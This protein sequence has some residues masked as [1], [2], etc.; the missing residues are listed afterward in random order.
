MTA[1]RT[2]DSTLHGLS[3]RSLI[4]PTP[5]GSLQIP[6]DSTISSPRELTSHALESSY[7]QSRRYSHSVAAPTTTYSAN[8]AA[9][10]WED[11]LIPFEDAERSRFSGGVHR[12]RSSSP[13]VGP[14]ADRSQIK[15]EPD[16]ANCQF[17]LETYTDESIESPIL[18]PSPLEV[19][20]SGTTSKR[21]RS[22]RGSSDSQ[23][24]RPNS[25]PL[26]AVNASPEMY[27]MMGVIRLDPFACVNGVPQNKNVPSLWNGEPRPLD[28]EPILLEWQVDLLEPLVPQ[29]PESEFAQLPEIE[30]EDGFDAVKLGV[31]GPMRERLRS[32]LS[33][34]WREGG[35]SGARMS[36]SSRGSA[37]PILR[38]L[39]DPK[40]EG[41]SRSPPYH[42]PR[43][44]AHGYI[45]HRDSEDNSA[46]FPLSN[47]SSVNGYTGLSTIAKTR[48]Q[49]SSIMDGILDQGA[50]MANGS[51]SR[52][53][54][55][56]CESPSLLTDI[57]N[58]AHHCIYRTCLL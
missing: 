42:T 33:A 47:G 16:E 25:V 39:H 48:G 14:A 45:G 7:P 12:E 19:S 46:E 50:G 44:T 17:I 36:T 11:G 56:S 53:R 58:G 3:Y 1:N 22:G 38:L 2:G 20:F 4:H 13:M 15:A 43:G 23:S 49:V 30:S 57:T 9:A 54:G 8:L 5:V 52:S 55:G 40:A 41:I 27:A 24:R 21:D 31:A 28:E 29:T 6:A 32:P 35:G 37:S 26:R 51:T 34:D 10:S 18:P